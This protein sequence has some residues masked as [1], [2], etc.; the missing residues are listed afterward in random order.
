M[1]GSETMSQTLW[2][3][4]TV[5]DALRDAQPVAGDYVTVWTGTS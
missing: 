1:V 3:A 4:A 5:V 2:R